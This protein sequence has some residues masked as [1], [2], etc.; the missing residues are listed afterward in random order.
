MYRRE[1][2]QEKLA[3]VFPEDPAP[4]K[5]IEQSVFDYSQ[6][7]S[8]VY[9][10]HWSNKNFIKEYS[11]N[12]RKI[13]FNL[14]LNENK[15]NILK[16]I[17]IGNWKPEDIVTMDHKEL[18]PE[19]WMQYHKEI[20]LDTEEVAEDHVGMFKCRKCKSRRT[21]YTQIQS[22]SADEPMTCHCYCY[23]CGNRWKF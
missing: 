4:A 20:P 23:N 18:Y 8:K 22:R 1:V 3:M 13:I 9:S 2:L 15:H 11:T 19:L 17:D 14:L 21:T 6:K 16:N 10:E 7:Q 5:E 12:A